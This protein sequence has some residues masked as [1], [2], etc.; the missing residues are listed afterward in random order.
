MCALFVGWKVKPTRE[1]VASLKPVLVSKRRVQTLIN[2]LVANNIWYKIAGVSFNADNLADL[3]PESAQH[4]DEAVPVAV[5]ICHLQSDYGSLA[6]TFDYTDQRDIESALQRDA[7]LDTLLMDTVGYAAGDYTPKDYKLMKAQSLSRVLD[8]GNFLKMQSGSQFINDR[9]PGLMSYLFPHLDPWGIGGFNKPNCHPDQRIS[10]ERQVQNLLKQHDSLF[11][12]DPRF[13]YVCW[14]ILQKR[15]VSKNTLFTVSSCE[16][17]TIVQEMKSLAP[18]LT[19]M[20]SS[21]ERDPGAKPSN[22][23]QKCALKLLNRLK[24][25]TKELK[26]SFGYKLC[27]QNE[28]RALIKKFGT[29][30][31]FVTLNPANLYNPLLGVIA[32]LT[33]DCWRLSVAFLSQTTLVPLLSSLTL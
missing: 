2:F 24:F 28:I 30:T 22:Q 19:N 7:H 3:Y 13:A 11:Q 15:E 31:L 4:V 5:E 9:D 14:N 29:P 32:G 26:G 33:A 21:W 20:I 1:N 17:D 6:A 25:A 27:R 10:F 8:S 12:K 16:R 18:E 23:Q